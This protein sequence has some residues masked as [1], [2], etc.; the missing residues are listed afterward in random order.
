MSEIVEFYREHENKYRKIRGQ[1]ENVNERFL[2]ENRQAQRRMLLDSYVFSVISVQTP[3][4]I[5]E[6]AY[7]RWKNGESLEQAFQSV[8]YRFNKADY[9][10][11][12]R[13]DFESIDRVIDRLL[14]GNVDGA[15]RLI[16]DRFKGVGTVKAAFT[17]AMLG[18]TSR[19]C[20]D[21]N[22]LN[23]AGIERG[24]MYDGVVISK[25][26]SF[27]KNIFNDVAAPLNRVLDNFMVQWVIFDY[28]R[29]EGV[30]FHE[31]FFNN[32]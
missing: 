27:V 7:R 16:V 24:D 1:L 30:T 28:A 8:N 3:V 11:E 12:T 20:I 5:H 29:G 14:N 2:T 32:L 19:A 26:Q 17:L 25:Y 21:T 15:H 18:F 13:T 22:V 23:V 10:R 4:T 31:V 6:D 9:I